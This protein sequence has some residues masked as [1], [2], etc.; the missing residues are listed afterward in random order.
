MHQAS[1]GFHC[2][3]CTKKGAQKVYQGVG[4]LRV[5][6]VLTQVLIGLNLLVFA[7]G[8]LLS[9]DIP[10]YLTGDITS[11]HI[12]FAV[13]AR[14]WQQGDT[15]YIVALPGTDPIGVGNGEWYRLVTSGFLHYGAF[16]IAVNMWALWVLGQSVE[17]YGGRA[18]LGAIYAV[19][20]LFGSFG[21]LLLSPDSFGAGASGAIF[22]LMGAMFIIFRVQGIPWQ[23]SPIVNVLVLNLIITFAVPG[24]SK[25]A[26]L[27]GLVGGALAAWLL[28]DLPRRAGVAK[29]LPWALCA[30]AGAASVV[31]AIVVASGA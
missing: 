28:F 2:P 17:Q 30:A 19:S 22:G 25:G 15:L 6:P 13:V 23:G 14:L 1:V 26:H 24:I 27:G 9:A 3:E 20:L 7:L 18:R 16:H 8:A 21:A 10:G 4:A 11:F 31:G 12:D 5:A 29:Q